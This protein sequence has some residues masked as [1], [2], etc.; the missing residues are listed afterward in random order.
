VRGA[1]GEFDDLDAALDVTL[2]V[3]E[4]LA[5]FR[6]EQ[7][8]EFVQVLVDQ[9]HEFEQDPPAALRVHGRP[10]ELALFRVGDHVADLLGT[11]QRHPGLDLAGAR[12]VDIAEA[13]R[14]AFNMLSVNVMG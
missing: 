7:G 12:I 5:V 6:G 4:G 11:G 9:I 3:E 1:G 2:R 14:G 10:F 8:G 13:P